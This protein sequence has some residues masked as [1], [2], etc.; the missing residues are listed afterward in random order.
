M[1]KKI[2]FGAMLLIVA[3][4][5]FAGPGQ[6]GGSGGK[7]VIEFWHIQNIGEIT[8]IIENAVKRFE[9]ANPDYRVNITIT[10]NDAYKQKIAV[11]VASQQLPDVFIS[12]TGGTTNEY[13]KAGLLADMTSYFNKDNYKDK[14]LEAGIAQATVN[15]KIYGVPVENAAI[16]GVFYN[17][18]LFAKYNI[19]VPSTI[20]E[21]EAAC[22]TL[23]QN[24][25][26]PFSLANKTQWTGLMYYQ[27]LPTRHG[28]L[29]PMAKA[30]DG[31]GS[32]EDPAFVWAG[33]KIQEWVKK[34]YFNDGFNGLDEDSGQSRTF[35][36][37]EQAAMQVQGSW[38]VGNVGAENPDFL[39]KVGFFNFPGDETGSG[40]AKTVTG[41]IGDNFYHISSK[42]QYPE[43]A[44]EMLKYL[45]DDQSVRERVALGRIPPVKNI[46]ITDPL[47]KQVFDAIQA[48]P[49]IQFWYD[50]SLTNEVA[51]ELKVAS[52]EVFGLTLTPQ[53]MM[54]RVQQAQTTALRK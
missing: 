4:L 17:K 6:Q 18:D 47:V 39:K 7:K 9:A 5:L 29:Q 37:T 12:W 45:L 23:K 38:F 46:T 43:A 13:I 11:A 10:A 16:E 36:Y 19:R 35:L 21:L 1:T 14:F 44:F 2:M 40:N 41:T 51:E 25:I 48:A 49:D 32:F 24:G 30:L 31:S 54:K 52:Q 33:Q 26:I 8:A 15:G 42:C 3:G 20:R 22:D 53:D 34:G 50:Q 27:V 28:G